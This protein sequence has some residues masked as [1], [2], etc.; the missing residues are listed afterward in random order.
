MRRVLLADRANWWLVAALV[1][2]TV[3]SLGPHILAAC[4]APEGK[5]G[6]GT[7]WFVNDYA[8]YESAMAQGAANPGWTIEDRFTA[9]PHQPA[10][11]FSI[12]VAIGKLAA[13]LGLQPSALERPLALA[14][15]L[16]YTLAL[17]RFTHT[18]ARPGVARVAA[19]LLALFGTGLGWLVMLTLPLHRQTGAYVGNFSYE[20]H[21]FGLLFSAPHVPLG[22]AA[23]LELARSLR[24]TVAASPRHLL[25]AAALGA[26]TA[27]LHPF[28]LPVLLAALVLAGLLWLRTEG[29]AGALLSGAAATLGALPVVLPT[30]LVF[31]TDPFWSATYT[32]QNVLPSPA[33]H[34]LLIDLGVV[35]V[36]AVLGAWF[37][38]GRIAPF[39]LLLWLMLA[40]AAMYAPVPYQ[41]RLAF[42][43]QPMLAVLAANA[44]AALGD[45]VAVRA[46][47]W[48]NL[49][50]ALLAGGGATF[51]AGSVVASLVTGG[52]LGV[53]RST[54]D[55]DAAAA[56]LRAQARPG[57]VIFATWDVGNYLAGQTPARVYGG[58]PVATLDAT[59]K[60][61]ITASYFGHG[62]D[63]VVARRLGVSWVVV[64]PE[65]AAGFRVSEPPAFERGAVRVYRVAR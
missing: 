31:G 35:L 2:A 61:L 39:G 57:E 18:F 43:L 20:L 24:P 46:R 33:P 10:F 8:Q 3:F 13:L 17:W 42:G 23:T 60:R 59:Q 30:V 55:L 38:R 16:L 58:H 63:L 27:L 50:T 53:Y 6:L 14:A 32:L 56:W 54:P 34:E 64:G 4:C 19:F 29:A 62:G 1:L 47:V 52:P 21:T 11:M 12:Y 7:V 9:E 41:R 51:L 26:A 22:M 36:L 48:A 45:S 40:L 44:L 28:H 65:P 25:G 5:T 15:V 37:L 49:G